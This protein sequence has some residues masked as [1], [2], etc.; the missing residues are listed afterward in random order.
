MSQCSGQ[1]YNSTGFGGYYPCSYKAKMHHEGKGYCGVH[2]PVKKAARVAEREAKVNASI[3]R[4]QVRAHKLRTWDGL[5]ETR[6]KI[7][8][9]THDPAIERLCAAALE[10]KLA[11]R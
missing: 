2:D 6:E 8:V 5:V 7:Q 9:Q 1:S 11:K 10:E 3:E 4:G